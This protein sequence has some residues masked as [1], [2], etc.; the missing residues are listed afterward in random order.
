MSETV[1]DDIITSL[2][3]LIIDQFTL[4]LKIKSVGVT[5]LYSKHNICA[6]LCF[7]RK[8]DG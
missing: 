3:I 2:H 6:I 7:M 5:I 8:L 4:A 1:V